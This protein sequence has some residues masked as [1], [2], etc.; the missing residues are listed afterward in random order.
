MQETCPDKLPCIRGISLSASMITTRVEG[1]GEH[2]HKILKESAKFF[3]YFSLAI[4]ER[5]DTIDTVQ[6]L[7]FI[8]GRCQI[9]NPRRVMLFAEFK[10]LNN[11]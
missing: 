9:Q 10:K 6:L 1:I 4:K 2:L 7:I 8:H 5:N 3:K 11:C